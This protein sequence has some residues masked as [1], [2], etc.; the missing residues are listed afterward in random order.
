MIPENGNVNWFTSKLCTAAQL[1]WRGFSGLVRDAIK[2]LNYIKKLSIYNG[3][4]GVSK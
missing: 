1:F 4:P 3:M 2:L